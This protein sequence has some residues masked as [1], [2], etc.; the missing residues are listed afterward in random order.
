MHFL[1]TT[2]RTK[3]VGQARPIDEKGMAEIAVRISGG[4]YNERQTMSAMFAA[5]R[6]RDGDWRQKAGDVEHFIIQ[7]GE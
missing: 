6:M 5:R 1:I 2:N 4:G 7:A 3:P